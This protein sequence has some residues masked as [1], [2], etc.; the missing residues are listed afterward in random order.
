M[1]DKKRD[2]S[3]SIFE[4]R[5]WMAKRP[6]SDFAIGKIEQNNGNKDS[7]DSHIGHSVESRLGIVRLEQQIEK[8]NNDLK[9][10]K[11]IAKDFKDHGGQVVDVDDMCFII[12]T[13]LG[14][15][16]LPSVYTKRSN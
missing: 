2:P 3:F 10:V 4:F 7:S 15:F 9:E 5:Y 11:V 12:E 14:V 16:N 6:Q 8:H 1:N 13:K